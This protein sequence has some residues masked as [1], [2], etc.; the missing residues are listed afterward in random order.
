MRKITLA[1]LAAATLAG[2]A[3]CGNDPA[4]PQPDLKPSYGFLGSG[5]FMDDTTDASPNG[6]GNGNGGGGSTGSTTTSPAPAS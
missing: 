6:R 1:L 3:A 4:A 2:A 5:G